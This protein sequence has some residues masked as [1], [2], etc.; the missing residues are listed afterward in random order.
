[1]TKQNV[2]NTSKFTSPYQNTPHSHTHTN[3]E[4]EQ[5]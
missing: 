5:K 1:M 4:K 3:V 2:I